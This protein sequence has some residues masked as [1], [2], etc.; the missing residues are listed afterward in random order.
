MEDVAGRFALDFPYYVKHIKLATKI[1]RRIVNHADYF[2]AYSIQIDR[3]AGLRAVK[4]PTK[5]PL[6]AAWYALY[7]VQ[8]C[9][10]NLIILAFV[11]CIICAVGSIV[12]PLLSVL[13]NLGGLLYESKGASH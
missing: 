3:T 4:Y 5:V 12:V 8:R 6:I 1:A 11:I 2:T 7:S 9:L 10:M 13:W